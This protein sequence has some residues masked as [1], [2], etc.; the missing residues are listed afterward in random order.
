M[1]KARNGKR[2]RGTIH[3]RRTANEQR[4]ADAGRPKERS[5]ERRERAGLVRGRRV[6]RVRRCRVP[7]EAE[8]VSARARRYRS[9]REGSCF[10][11]VVLE[12]VKD[13]SGVEE[14]EDRPSQT[15]R[16]TPSKE[17]RRLG[18]A[19]EAT[20]VRLLLGAL[21]RQSAR[22]AGKFNL[23]HL[24]SASTAERSEERRKETSSL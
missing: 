14:E 1:K 13:R 2:E 22:F 3:P 18:R 12:D 24:K 7:T 6:R 16:R 23:F 15:D 11:F 4:N 20:C 9:G 5:H 8:V 17:G 10:A 21:P 19:S